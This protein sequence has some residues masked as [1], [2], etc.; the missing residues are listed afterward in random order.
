MNPNAK[1]ILTVRD[2]AEAWEKSA[3]ETIFRI[4]YDSKFAPGLLNTMMNWVPILGRLTSLKRLG[5]A[6][7][8][9]CSVQGRLRTV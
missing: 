2:S 1:V 6:T 8:D 4:I 9:K 3:S 5:V 7:M